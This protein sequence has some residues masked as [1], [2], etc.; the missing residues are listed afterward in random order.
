MKVKLTLLLAL[1]MV[2]VS[3]V[4]AMAQ[5]DGVQIIGGE[6]NPEAV[7]EL[8]GYIAAPYAPTGPVKVYVGQLPE[9]VPFDLPLP[10]NSRVV[11]SI[12]SQTGGP[13]Y[14]QLYLASDLPAEDLITYFQ[15]TLP[16]QEWDL[17]N[18]NPGGPRGFNAQAVMNA[19][20]CFQ[21]DEA[22]IDM[23]AFG[24]DEGQTRVFAYVALED[25]MYPC[26][27]N[28]QAAPTDDPYLMLPNLETPEGVE[29]ATNY[30]GGGGGGGGFGFRTASTSTFLRSELT[31]T[32]IIA[33]YNPQLEAQGWTL[34]S[35]SDSPALAGSTWTLTD[36]DGDIWGAIFSIQA[37]P[38]QENLYYA[39]VLIVEGPSQD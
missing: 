31:A 27:Q 21:G 3:V 25:A 34:V 7:R 13:A 12:I 33:L 37:S 18:S 16:T 26:N 22:F 32:E 17:I 23:T 35:N 38:S 1:L 29:I 4:P 19:Q 24:S 9:E 28:P 14:T 5:E 30:G 15:E 6:D 20:F 10:E 11:G 8:L 39:E 36:E 2:L